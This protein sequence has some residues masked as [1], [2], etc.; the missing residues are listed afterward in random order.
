ML[1]VDRDSESGEDWVVE[2]KPVAQKYGLGGIWAVWPD[3]GD[4]TQKLGA[5]SPANQVRV[6]GGDGGGCCSCV[7]HTP[8]YGEAG[9]GIDGGCNAYPFF[10]EV[11][12]YLVRGP[13]TIVQYLFRLWKS[14]ADI[15]I[16]DGH[17]YPSRTFITIIYHEYLSWISMIDVGIPIPD[18][19]P[20]P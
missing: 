10:C 7:G 19:E 15:H 9:A 14:I 11:D 6:Q 12:V 18:P 2:G 16:H 13:C 1:W 8:K 5:D 20:N 3:L 4:I 17:S